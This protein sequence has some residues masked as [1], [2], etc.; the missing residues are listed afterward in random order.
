M[1][2]KFCSIFLIFLLVFCTLPTVFAEGVLISLQDAVEPLEL[3]GS[4]ISGKT[5]Y[6]PV[7]NHTGESMSVSLLLAVYQGNSRRLLALEQSEAVIAA[8]AD[9][10]QVNMTGSY[11]DVS[12]VKLMIFNDMERLKPITVAKGVIIHEKVPF[13][14]I[15]DYEKELLFK[16]SFEG[17]A[18]PSNV[19]VSTSYSDANIDAT[20]G[21]GGGSSYKVKGEASKSDREG[22]TA[23]V[24]KINNLDIKKG[25]GILAQVQMKAEGLSGEQ[26]DAGE[27]T[28][29]EGCRTTMT[30]SNS[31]TG[32][33]TDVYL[34]DE[35]I[36]GTTDWVESMQ[37]AV[38]EFDVDT[39]SV[40]CY[41]ESTI[42]KGT[43][44]YDEISL[45]HLGFDPFLEAVLETPNYKGFIYGENGIG[46]INLSTSVKDYGGL[47]DLDSCRV[48]AQVVDALDTVQMSATIEDV[49]EE[50]KISFSSKDLTMGK[51]YY[52]QLIL[53]NKTTG[54]NYSFREWTLRK[55][56]ETYRPNHYFDEHG[57]FVIDGEPTFL[58]GIYGMNKLYDTIDN[59]EGTPINILMP[60]G[61]GWL[62]SYDGSQGKYI[63]DVDEDLLDYAEA[64]DVKLVATLGHHIYSKVQSTGLFSDI[65]TDP[66]DSRKAF[67]QYAE[68]L[69][70]PAIL[71]Y[72]MADEMAAER[73]GAE[74]EWASRILSNS[75]PDGFTF[76]VSSYVNDIRSQL[77]FTDTANCSSYSVA[78]GDGTDDLSEVTE[79]LSKAIAVVPQGNRPF[80]GVLQSWQDYNAERGPTEEEL[81]NMAWQAVAMGLQGIIWYSYFDMADEGL[82]EPS[83]PFEETWPMLIKVCE[84]LEAYYPV[85]LSTEPSPVVEV[86]AGDWLT[87]KAKRHEGKSYLFTTNTSRSEQIA[88]IR[89]ENATSIRGVYSNQSFEAD[90]DGWFTVMYPA[91][92]VEVFEIEQEAYRSP[93]AQ[94]SSLGF[95]NDT[96]SYFVSEN[97]DDMTIHI[98]TGT[99]TLH[100]AADI[101]DK[102]RIYFNGNE[103]AA[104]GSLTL[105]GVE[106]FVVCV[107]AEDARYQTEYTYHIAWD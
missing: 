30:Y 53:E 62:V 21:Y 39:V 97:G 59:L 44:W 6:F 98:P 7:E 76:N 89:L 83:A 10:L 1:L 5:L 51:D 38:C 12:E 25:S 8:D 105:D 92:G 48:R 81:R 74:V 24:Y 75:D 3:S 100:Y 20:V 41:L 68:L 19:T 63:I 57:R 96:T 49:Q 52:L 107:K 67:T 43:A 106:Q 26:A 70:H 54:Q 77:R 86:E 2:K 66:Q 91:I 87:Y 79:R 45:Y 95:F 64:H 13:Y 27:D 55:R 103:Q 94:L 17:E 80:Y 60:Y 28:W 15:N 65:I 99:K 46:D 58:M 18:L 82:E 47:Y 78:K 101:S 50:I 56:P 35:T 9:M 69:D 33:Y 36:N 90:G 42:N 73:Y 31:V 71:G 72:Y 40:M 16:Q 102:A 88:R 84:E 104:C 32:E 29:A 4:T 34:I 93:D 85:I 23:L 22:G 11:H 37:Y 14:D 61:Y